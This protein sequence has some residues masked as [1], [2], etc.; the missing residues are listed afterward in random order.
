MMA[1]GYTHLKAQWEL[2]ELLPSGSLAISAGFSEPLVP[3]G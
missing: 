3:T 1:Q 2:W